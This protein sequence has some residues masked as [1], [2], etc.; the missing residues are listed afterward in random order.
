MSKLFLYL[1]P[2]LIII[3]L[4]G[5][6]VMWKYFQHEDLTMV[7]GKGY[8]EY[9]AEIQSVKPAQSL[10]PI[11]LSG[12]TAYWDENGAIT[13]MNAHPN[14]I[15]AI[16]P[17][18]YRL[19][20][21]GHVIEIAESTKKS[22]IEEL[23]LRLK[24]EIF[25]TIINEFNPD[26]VSALMDN[27]EL[28]QKTIDEL[29]FIALS[30]GYRGWDLDWEELYV[31][32]KG[33]FNYFVENLAKA[34]HEKNLL[35]SITVQAKT[36]TAID[37]P[38]SEAQDWQILSQHADEVRIM[39]YDYHHSESEAGAVTPL[40]VYEKTLQ[41]AV[42]QIPLE[43]LNISLPAYGYDWV[44]EKGKDLQ[45]QEAVD[46]LT[47]KKVAWKRDQ[48]SGALTATYKEDR[49]MHEVWFDDAESAQIKIKMA[50]SLG[51]NKFSFW[52]IGGEDPKI[53]GIK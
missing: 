22:Q 15:K 52:R 35:L 53:W 42:K 10:P 24:I 38:S 29:V 48:V 19:N 5:G 46:L 47:M 14:E 20:D 37:A 25:P 23:A 30:K 36:G 6:F 7:N 8:E 31:G 9:L 41:I 28:Q 40:D 34:L 49:I 45:Y 18:W 43:K 11:E 21:E 13:S 4:G 26:R 27:Q 12:W 44:G 39:A 32:D 3:I 33:G 16:M 51:I 17:F 50:Q 2:F 1:I